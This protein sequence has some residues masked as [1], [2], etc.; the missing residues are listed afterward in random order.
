M[1][2][3]LGK[4]ILSRL[5]VLARLLALPVLEGK[6]KREQMAL[7]AKTGMQPKEIA[8]FIGT[9]SQSVRT[10]LSFIR[11]RGKKKR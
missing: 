10:E 8:E 7:L 4:E 6:T 3:D 9:T 11:K 2:E 1:P 5:D